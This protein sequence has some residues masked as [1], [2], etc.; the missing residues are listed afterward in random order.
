MNLAAPSDATRPG[1]H[2]A[3]SACARR[4]RKEGG[5]RAGAREAHNPLMDAFTDYP[6]PRKVG[7][8]L[9][10]ALSRISVWLAGLARA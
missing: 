8:S 3:A 1:V 6:N 5:R 10:P 2:A 7:P 9:P 4:K